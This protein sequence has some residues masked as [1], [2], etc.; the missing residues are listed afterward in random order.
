MHVC[1]HTVSMQK[2]MYNIYNIYTRCILFF[3]LYSVSFQLVSSISNDDPDAS[4]SQRRQ[5]C[6]K[7]FRDSTELPLS[8]FHAHPLF[9]F[10]THMRAHTH[11]H[12]NTPIHTRMHVGAVARLRRGRLRHASVNASVLLSSGVRSLSLTHRVGN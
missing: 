8:F 1:M 12:T 2:Y 4:F 6:T 3:S 9:F 5:L 7:T 10:H 11:T